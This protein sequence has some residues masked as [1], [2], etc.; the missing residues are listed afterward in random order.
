MRFNMLGIIRPSDRCPCVLLNARLAIVGSVD[1][2]AQ[3]LFAF[4]TS[5]QQGQVGPQ[6]IPSAALPGYG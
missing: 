4:W 3:R 6:V 5:S 2:L 1:L